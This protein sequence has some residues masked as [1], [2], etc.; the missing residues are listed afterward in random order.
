MYPHGATGLGGFFR[1]IL[2]FLLTSL[3]DL[4]RLSAYLPISPMGT[5]KGI[6]AKLSLK[7]DLYCLHQ[8]VKSLTQRRR[9]ILMGYSSIFESVTKTG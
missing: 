4:Y 8:I 2:S 9:A 3:N 5:L 7:I 1:H 6:I